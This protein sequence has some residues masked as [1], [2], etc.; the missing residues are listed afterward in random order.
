MELASAA[1]GTILFRCARQ[2][3]RVWPHRKR[4]IPVTR[5]RWTVIE[6]R[7]SMMLKDDLH[8]SDASVVQHISMPERLSPKR[9]SWN[10]AQIRSEN[11]KPEVAVRRLLHR[12]GYRYRRGRSELP[13]RPDIVLTRWKTIVFVHGCF[14]HQHRGCIDCSRPATNSSYWLPKLARNVSR[15]RAVRR[16]LRRAG[17]RVVV[18]WECECKDLEA[19]L[20]RVD[21]AAGRERLES[22]S[23]GNAK[24][25]LP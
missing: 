14:W 13:G 11:T 23:R 2:L 22:L 3:I 16:A 4:L 12:A 24:H 19:V 18:V 8:C 5:T 25:K 10:M 7:K 20:R 21:D 1:N 9:R 17:W 15:D 6:L